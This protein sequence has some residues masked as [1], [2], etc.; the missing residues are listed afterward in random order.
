MNRHLKVGTAVR[1]HG[2]KVGIAGAVL[3]LAACG[4]S[5][6]SGHAAG[7]AA[8]SAGQSALTTLQADPG[9]QNVEAAA[10]Q[11]PPLTGHKLT[12]VMLVDTKTMPR[13]ASAQIWE[14][15]LTVGRA[16]Q[17]SWPTF[18]TCMQDKLK[19]TK[20]QR[21]TM[22]TCIGGNALSIHL[23]TLKSGWVAV[24]NL[25]VHTFLTCYD[26]AAGLVKPTSPSSSGTGST[27]PP[28][29]SPSSS[30]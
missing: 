18:K 20:A 29:P 9:G 6:G 16:L 4:A 10:N 28:A 13:S 17:K 11:C 8:A 30:S 27:S 19:L 23:A 24:Q 1:R 21:S 2:W 15:R 5:T 7:S 3:A 14:Q 12:T 26:Q 22:D 25:I